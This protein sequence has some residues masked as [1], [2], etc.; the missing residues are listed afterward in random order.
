MVTFSIQCLRGQ[1]TGLGFLQL[2]KVHSFAANSSGEIPHADVSL[3]VATEAHLQYSLTVGTTELRAEIGRSKL[4]CA[5][6]DPATGRL[7]VLGL[8]RSRTTS[9]LYSSVTVFFSFVDCAAY[10]R[11]GAI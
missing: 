10:V 5:T 6:S 7:Y 3:T 11:A 8:E 4:R 9:H 2:S 1:A